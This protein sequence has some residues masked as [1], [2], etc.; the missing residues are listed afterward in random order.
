M[1]HSIPTVEHGGGGCVMD[2]AVS[3]PGKLIIINGAID[4]E[5]YQQILKENVTTSVLR[6]MLRGCC[7]D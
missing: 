1:Q 3:G 2:S 6:F 5:N 4:S 7:I